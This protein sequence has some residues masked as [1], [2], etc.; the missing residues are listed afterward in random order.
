MPSLA[1]F[2]YRR[3]LTLSQQ[4]QVYKKVLVTLQWESASIMFR[5][6]GSADCTQVMNNVVKGVMNSVM[7]QHPLQQ[8]SSN[9]DSF[10]LSL[11]KAGI[12]HVIIMKDLKNT[13]HLWGRNEYVTNEPQRTSAGRLLMAIHADKLDPTHKLSGWIITM[14]TM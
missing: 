7:N 14:P 3:T 9:T 2:T 5:L 13:D 4:R 10:I 8:R 12:T 11:I 6:T 1:L